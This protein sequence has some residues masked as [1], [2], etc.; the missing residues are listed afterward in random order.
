MGQHMI[1][2][3]YRFR[4]CRH[5]CI[6]QRTVQTSLEKQLK[7]MGPITSRGGT[8]PEFLKKHMVTCGFPGGG[9]FGTPVPPLDPPMFGTNHICVKVSY[10]CLC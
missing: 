5:Q 1:F 4:K 8:T 10:K 6:S 7:S 9:G 3:M 2:G